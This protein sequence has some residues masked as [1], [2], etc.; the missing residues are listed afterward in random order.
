V[1]DLD[2]GVEVM[3]ARDQLQHK[4]WDANRGT[5]FLLKDADVWLSRLRVQREF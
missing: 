3:Y 4:Q 2:I 5:S 1:K